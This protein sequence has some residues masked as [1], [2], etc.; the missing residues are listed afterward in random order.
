MSRQAQTNIMSFSSPVY[1]ALVKERM[2]DSFDSLPPLGFRR[3]DPPVA[4]GGSWQEIRLPH[5][6]GVAGLAEGGSLKIVFPC[7]SVWADF[8]TVDPTGENSV[9]DGRASR[10][11]RS[12]GIEATP[13]A[14]V[15]RT[16]GDRKPGDGGLLSFPGNRAGNACAACG[17]DSR[18]P[19]GLGSKLT[20]LASHLMGMTH[21]SPYSSDENN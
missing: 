5:T 1:G 8:R 12:G 16:I 15:T 17:P 21:I 6:R 13:R 10:R 20:H 18:I 7:Y 9:S 11:G 2:A 3:S 14:F 4:K 19:S